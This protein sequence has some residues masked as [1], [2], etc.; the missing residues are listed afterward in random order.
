VDKLYP[1]FV[2]RLEGERYRL[3]AEYILYC[4]DYRLMRSI[5]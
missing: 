3:V 5:S 1:A 4:S 2:Y